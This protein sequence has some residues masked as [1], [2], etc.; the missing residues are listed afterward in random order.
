VSL[1]V[2]TV[3]A[4]NAHAALGDAVRSAKG[5]SVLRPVTVLVPTNAAGVIARRALGRLGG[6]AAVDL[7]TLYRLAE[8]LAGPSLRAEQRL[9]VSTAVVDL[10]V[11]SVLR[12]TRTAFDAVAEHPSTVVALR[13]VHRE[14][15][16]AGPGAVD[17]LE[18]ATSRGRDVARVSRLVTQRLAA[19]WYDE[20]DLLERAVATV[21]AGGLV[22]SL[23]EVILFLPQ[24]LGA[25][26]LELV[27]A[28]SEAGSVRV[29]AGSSGD[30]DADRDVLATAAALGQPVDAIV[31][32]VLADVEVV[33][34]T[35]ADEE[36]RHAVRTVVAAA[37]EGVPLASMA[38]LWPTDRP[39]A[40]LVEHHL[41]AAGIAWNGRPGTRVSE[42]Q[43]PRFLLD[44]LDVDRRG[45]RRRDLFDLL[46]DVPL[47][48]SEGRPLAAWER[49]GREAGVVK[50]DQ[51]TPRLKA[52]AHRQ[53][54]RAEERRRE[55]E[56]ALDTPISSPLADA[57]ESLAEFVTALRRDLGHRQATRRWSEWADWAEAQIA[58]RLATSRLPQLGEPEMQAW[59]HTTRVLDRLRH[60]DGVGPPATRSDFRSVFA[61]EFD[62]APGRLGRIGAGITIG[63]L[64]GAVGLVA[65]VVIVV[66]AAEGLMPAPPSVDP[67]IG[68]GDRRAAGLA[69]S[70][71]DADRA[72]RQLLA[73]LQSV[74]RVVITTPRGDLRNTTQRQP[75]RWLAD[76]PTGEQRSVASHTAGLLQTDFPAHAGEHRLRGRCAHVLH[77]GAADLSSLAASD[78]D[79]VLARALALR[80][81][82]RSELLT[83]FDGDLSAVG[84]PAFERPVSPTQLQAWAAC[85][86]GYFVQ[87][88]LGVRPLEEPEDALGITPLDRGNALHEVL[89]L[90]NREV[91][92]GALPQPSEHGWSD[93]HRR[94]LFE[95]LEQTADRFEQTGRTGRPASWAIERV[96]LHRELQVWAENDSGKVAT[97]RSRVIASEQRFGADG[98]VTLALLDG[99]RLM[100]YGSVDRIDR[101][102]NGLVVTDH[103]VGSDRTYTAIDRSDPTAG[104]T[105]F[106][107]PAYAAAAKLIA[108]QHGEPD[109]GPV[110]AE[111]AFFDKG[112]YNRIGYEFD[113]EV[114]TLV[115]NDL[116]YVV[117]GI[118]AGWFPPTPLKPQFTVYVDCA[119]CEPDELGTAERW[120]E[121]ERKRHDP[122]LA[123][124][125]PP[126]VAES[127]EVAEGGAA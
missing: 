126:D 32:P 41:D 121:W 122:R 107:L 43:V 2:T 24:T 13:D 109:T 96:R 31:P 80:E 52:Y 58:E 84:V 77:D 14:L 79:V 114:W 105:R 100:V 118:E 37:R 116:Q 75:S 11:R 112:G 38:I 72:H 102:P 92:E 16:N 83:P 67:L 17:R 103:K 95:L 49:A 117:S 29:L 34:V 82:R 94:R 40:R 71:S 73:V 26:D 50:D 106:Q 123:T 12:S 85:P 65:D 104:R 20:G 59:E 125:F 1:S 62:V 66:G 90:F 19:E 9:P 56:E 120:H 7:I 89:D 47:R 113:D 42:R 36:V 15:R 55:H 98:D 124:W 54:R 5:G 91:I 61:A 86:H 87:Y 23:S 35:D 57:A 27:R 108:K 81:A 76:L 78:G 45:L 63:S 127:A 33:S 51:W 8:R 6:V 18:Q 115:A 39:Y 93:L 68:D 48:G 110:L 70:D 46:A 4:A 22:E 10:A 111:Y 28:L 25:L 60:L 97:R 69:T 44:L 3:T 64:S 53:R 101:T 119:F 30:P 99:R 74:P 21:R 88:L